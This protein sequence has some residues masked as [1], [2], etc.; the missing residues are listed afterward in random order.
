[1]FDCAGVADG[2]AAAIVVRAEDAH[3]YTDNR[4]TSALSLVQ[5]TAAGCRDPNYDYTDLP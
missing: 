5:A 4:C 2:G 3:K 1:V